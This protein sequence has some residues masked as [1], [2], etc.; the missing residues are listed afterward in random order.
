MELNSDIASMWRYVY[1]T[2]AFRV[3][4]G[5]ESPWVL[6]LNSSRYQGEKKNVC[7]INTLLGLV[8]IQSTMDLWNFES[9][10]FRDTMYICPLL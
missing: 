3:T 1:G 10:P 4:E 8:G 2:W 7:L 6:L 5:F 9:H